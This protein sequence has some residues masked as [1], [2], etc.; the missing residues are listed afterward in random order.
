[1][2]EQYQVALLLHSLPM[3]YEQLRAAYMVKCMVQTSELHKALVMQ[4]VHF[5]EQGGDRGSKTDS[6]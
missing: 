5:V 3:E 4:E 6:D 2:T 1:M